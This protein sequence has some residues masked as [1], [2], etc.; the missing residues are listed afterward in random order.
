MRRNSANSG[1]ETKFN[2]MHAGGFSREEVSE[3][4][5][6]ETAE[7]EDL[8]GGAGEEEGGNGEVSRVG[9]GIGPRM[10]RSKTP[11]KTRDGSRC[12]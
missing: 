10:R 5:E 2:E 4:E 7:A 11:S 6:E 1:G 9:E 12:R 3:E 8:E